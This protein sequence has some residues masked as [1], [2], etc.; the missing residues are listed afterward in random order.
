MICFT[1][2]HGLGN[3]FIL[4]NLFEE[5]AVDYQR[6]AK[7]WCHRQLG[8]GGDGLVLIAPP[9]DPANQLRMRIYNSDGSEADMCGN[10]IRCFAKYVY[11]KGL[12]ADEEFRVETKA[13][14]MIP[15]VNVANGL[16]TGVRVD[17]GQPRFRPEEVPVR[18]EGE[19]VIDRE[20]PIGE[21][22]YRINAVFMG[23]PHCVIFQNDVDQFPLKEVGPGIE[24]D[25]LFPARVNVEFVEVLNRKEVKMRV[26]ERGA[27]LTMACGT[28]ACAAAVACVKNEL[29][30][31]RV[32][33]H[34]PGGDL[35]IEWAENGRVYMTGPAAY[36]FTG[37][38]NETV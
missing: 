10:A 30:D 15:R 23:N 14:I 7:D 26:W 11:E 31:R 24:V 4:V 8:I 6:V 34:L 17:M 37:E 5:S 20:V 38:I 32:T 12:V 27:G 1:K 22:V 35:E 29:T 18:L 19:E 25:P 9:E 13:G 16:V 21:G 36:V 28:G 33:V 3:D 2:M